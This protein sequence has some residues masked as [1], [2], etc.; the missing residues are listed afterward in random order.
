MIRVKSW[1]SCRFGNL[2]LF[3][4][5]SEVALDAAGDP[6]SRFASMQAQLLQLL[7]ND[8]SRP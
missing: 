2:L 5:I 1:A 3:Q 8:F 4:G 6:R 7:A